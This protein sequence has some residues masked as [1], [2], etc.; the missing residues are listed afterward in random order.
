MKKPTITNRSLSLWR[1]WLVRIFLGKHHD[2][3]VFD[4]HPDTIKHCLM[5]FSVCLAVGGVVGATKAL[6]E[7]EARVEEEAQKEILAKKDLKIKEKVLTTNKK[8][9]MPN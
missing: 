8:N 4:R 1:H 2:Y 3:V 6:D 7:E 9:Y 5:K